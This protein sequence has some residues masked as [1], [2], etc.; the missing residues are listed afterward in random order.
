MKAAAMVRVVALASV[1]LVVSGCAPPGE[2]LTA[3]GR[4][5]VETV[6]A[7]RVRVVWAEVWQN[8]EETLITGRL[9]GRGT[10]SRPLLGHVDV[11]FLDP[12]RKVL[13]KARSKKVYIRRTSPGK[14][15]HLTPFEVHV[16]FAPPK[17]TRV[18]IACEDGFHNR[19]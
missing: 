7:E 3:S 1:V 8:G 13:K 4:V 14:G 18:V 6:P 2:N 19:P 12:E 11:T 5:S 15:P 9:V 16:K 17:N 10:Y